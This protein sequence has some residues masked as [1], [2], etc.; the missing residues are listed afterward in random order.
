MPAQITSW[1]GRVGNAIREFTIAQRT[2]ALLGVAVVVLGIAALGLWASAPSYTPLFTGLTGSDA[3][4]IVTQLRT[5]GVPYQLSDGGATILVPQQNV[6]DERLKAAA[7]GMPSSNAGGYALLDKMGVTSSEFQQ[8]VTYKRAM[9][10]ELAATIKALN[11]VKNASV[12]LAIPQATV[13]TSQT[14]DPT[15]S[16]FVATDQGVT[17]TAEQ[18][19]AIV[20]LTSSS[21]EGMKASDVAVVDAAGNVLSTV[22][23]GAVGSVDKQASDYEGRVRDAVQAMLDKVVGPGNATVV[24]AADMNQQTAQQVQETY[25][26]PTSAPALNQ[27]TTTQSYTG[28]GSSVPGVL[29]STSVPVPT[30]S[31]GN[32][33]YSSTADTRNNALDK[34]TTT[35][36]I[37]PG[38]VKRQTV[39][40]A[41]NSNAQGV[42]VA[43]ITALVSA[44]AGID[45]TR[46]DAVSVQSV[47]FNTT[48][49][50]D[51]A[52]ALAAADAAATAD[53]VGGIIRTAIITLGVAAP[54]VL[55]VVLFVRRSR[56]PSREA[57]DLDELGTLEDDP[58]F[59]EALAPA[60]VLTGTPVTSALATSIDRQRAEIASLAERDPA[61]TAEY[62]RTLMDDR[63]TV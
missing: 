7:A 59:M 60:P 57:V 51:A 54:I 18:V 15:A 14:I 2:L 35:T 25:T 43:N 38:S 47:A 34:L 27:S 5:D 39:S 23:G 24:V 63:Q 45:R 40:V 17:L 36:N 31:N 44:A 26:T 12:H 8:S 1:L 41:L 61:G 37:P 9:E 49:A 4:T 32:G 16:V 29:G 55:G 13:F 62:L 19:Q 22:G 28:S 30:G 48:A 11:G 33:A 58:T 3:N 42:S 52:A 10:G 6:Y 53:Q 56:K 20:H 21:I 50:K 46:G